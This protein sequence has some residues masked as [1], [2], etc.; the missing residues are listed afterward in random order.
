MA[1]KGLTDKEKWARSL[2]WETHFGD[3]GA[4]I[5]D[6]LNKGGM[7]ADCVAEAIGE[8]IDLLRKMDDFGARQAQY[9]KA[10]YKNMT[11]DEIKAMRRM[12]VSALKKSPEGLNAEVIGNRLSGFATAHAQNLANWVKSEAWRTSQRNKLEAESGVGTVDSIKSL[13]Q[14]V[15]RSEFRGYGNVKPHIQPLNMPIAVAID[16]NRG[17]FLNI[18]E[19]AIDAIRADKSDP[20]Y[21]AQIADNPLLLT[22]MI[23]YRNRGGKADV[24]PDS[25]LKIHKAATEAAEKF[26]AIIEREYDAHE[27]IGTP[28]AHIENY[29]KRAYGYDKLWANIQ[30]SLEADGIDISRYH[31]YDPKVLD[32]IFKS[33]AAQD[34]LATFD[35]NKY[36]DKDG[37]L[38][39]DQ[40]ADFVR[41]LAEPNEHEK[42]PARSTVSSA[43]RSGMNERILDA[44]NPEAEHLFFA[45][46]GNETKT[47]FDLLMSEMKEV[48][49][50]RVAHE[51]YGHG[52]LDNLEW[53]VHDQIGR[54]K[55]MGV[56]SEE[57]AK[58][59][60]DDYT[61]RMDAVL[62]HYKSDIKAHASAVALWDALTQVAKTKLGGAAA[63]VPLDIARIAASQARMSQVS[64]QFATIINGPNGSTLKS[65]GQTIKV[66]FER[67]E[68]G[69]TIATEVANH[70]ELAGLSGIGHALGKYNMDS[71]PFMRQATLGDTVRAIHSGA[72]KYGKLLDKLTMLGQGHSL[73]VNVSMALS[74]STTSLMSKHLDW[75]K[76]ATDAPIF[77]DRISR[78]GI[79]EADW[80]T[81]K[82]LKFGPHEMLDISQLKTTDLDLFH[83]MQAFLYDEANMTLGV[84]DALTRRTLSGGNA[85]DSYMGLAYKSIFGFKSFV[86]GALMQSTPRTIREWQ[87]QSK[88]NPL[89]VGAQMASVVMIGAAIAMAKEYANGRDV[90]LEDT[91]FWLVQSAAYTGPWWVML[92]PMLMHKRQT[93]QFFDEGTFS[94]V[95]G[96]LME[97]L[98]IGGPQVDV[99]GDLS[100]AL[101]YGADSM[102]DSAGEDWREHARDERKAIQALARN[103]PTSANPFTRAFTYQFLNDYFYS[104]D[105]SY[106]RKSLKAKVY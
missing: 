50:S 51:L 100:Q 96:G 20:A 10:G 48:T 61:R 41:S 82:T 53:L 36:R 32:A 56:I 85:P 37:V 87:M 77:F 67:G 60:R 18:I 9:N 33:E 93:G 70:F 45:K 43:Y 30:K 66:L 6:A 84:P 92:D 59:F 58:L 69:K 83:R 13:I 47:S 68:T 3:D 7:D 24:L 29:A 22:D 62:M 46:W 55:L 74:W 42:H 75:A 54:A 38:I 31:D 106:M 44:V 76:L 14:S 73:A 95:R 94:D 23:I 79:L 4:R 104:K 40:F 65:I 39:K 19:A 64:S 72:R 97:T 98:K 21:A 34:I 5:R 16:V 25:G 17:A 8:M 78:A 90:D 26:K 71:T 2:I 101:L 35:M 1:N 99:V 12:F 103:A 63:F 80:G 15:A 102:Y 28:R 86:M 57:E 105:P 81:L 91:S 89:S 88:I 11:K 27:R 52:G 49:Q